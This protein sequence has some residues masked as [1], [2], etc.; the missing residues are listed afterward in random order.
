[1]KGDDIVSYVCFARCGK[2]IIEGSSRDDIFTVFVTTHPG[3]RRKGLATK[4]I[5]ELLHGIDLDYRVAYKT[6]AD[7]NIGSIAVA[8]I[9]GYAEMYP[10]KR[11]PLLKTISKAESGTWRLYSYKEV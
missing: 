9:N 5:D 8:K 7:S 11:S 6:I 3:Y 1:M 10:A 2:T 4:I